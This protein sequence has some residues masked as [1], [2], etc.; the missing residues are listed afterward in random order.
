M[1]TTSS[2]S[3]AGCRLTDAIFTAALQANIQASNLF[4]TTQRLVSCY[5]IVNPSHR[6][7]YKLS[8]DSFPTQLINAVSVLLPHVRIHLG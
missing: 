7:S 1:A 2:S 5:F 6:H 3:D 4:I 8:L